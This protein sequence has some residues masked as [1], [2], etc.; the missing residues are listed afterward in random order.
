MAPGPETA[1][2]GSDDDSDQSQGQ[3]VSIHE[4]ARNCNLSQLRRALAAGASPNFRDGVG[5]VAAIHLL[6]KIKHTDNIGLGARLACLD[7]LRHS[8]EFDVN[9]PNDYGER[10]IH[11]S[12]WHARSSDD[13]EFMQA[14]VDAGADVNAVTGSRRGTAVHWSIE[15]RGGPIG[16][17]A[18]KVDLLIR[19]GASVTAGDVDGCTPLDLAISKAERSL[20]RDVLRLRAMRRV[21][22]VLLAAGAPLPTEARDTYYLPTEV[23]DTYLLR[24]MQAGSFANYARNH[25]ATLT[26]MLTPRRGPSSPLRLVPPEVLRKIVAFAFHV[27]YY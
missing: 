16:A 20:G 4:A 23:R 25:L 9:L 27:G 15:A 26:E 3:L 13:V 7:L 10:A 1:G 17:A 21:Y 19:A 14:V 24:V 8:P 22:P 18:A 2:S 12:A 6:C 5:H 11:L